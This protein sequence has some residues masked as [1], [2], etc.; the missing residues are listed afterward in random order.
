M[1]TKIVAGD[2]RGEMKKVTWIQAASLRPAATSR[3]AAAEPET[4]EALL[5][6]R[7]V[8]WEQETQHRVAESHEKGF[9]EGL[10][11]GAARAEAAFCDALGRVGAAAAGIAEQRAAAI[12]RAE[13]DMVTLAIEIARRVLHRELTV[14]P[15][16]VEA[17][18]KA[19]LEKLQ[20][21]ETAKLRVH[22]DHVSPIQSAL[23]KL[24]KAAQIVVI[25]DPAQ[26]P[27]AAVFDLSTGMLDASI[28]TQLREIERGL[29]DQ[30]QR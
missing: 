14:D 7:A 9:Q 8:Q 30:L 16:A 20:T 6:Q 23:E 29:V 3:N 26:E 12:A 22:P 1:L 24:G 21:R 19:A 2:A 18:V 15:C 13:S 27:G 4:R 25:G 28:D 10:A 11:A 5:R 17:L